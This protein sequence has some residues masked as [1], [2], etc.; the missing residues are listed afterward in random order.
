MLDF[1]SI[2][3][4]DTVGDDAEEEDDDDIACEGEDNATELLL[5]KS[6]KSNSNIQYKRFLR[7]NFNPRSTDWETNV[8][9]R[10]FKIL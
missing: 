5:E 10:F 7:F 2:D 8:A 1:E 4:D 6:H 3:R 9:H